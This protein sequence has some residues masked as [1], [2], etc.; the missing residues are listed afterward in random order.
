MT[1]FVLFWFKGLFHIISMRFLTSSW[2]HKYKRRPCRSWATTIT[3]I[4]LYYFEFDGKNCIDYTRNWGAA[5]F[6]SIISS[7]IYLHFN[8][9]AA[10]RYIL[11]NQ[12]VVLFVRY[13]NLSDLHTHFHVYCF[14]SVVFYPEA[15]S[16]RWTW[17]KFVLLH[18]WCHA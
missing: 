11:F 6:F 1:I 7:N 15:T 10:N 17:T 2:L 4:M 9:I 12:Y 5:S 13:V 8:G 3:F 14:E 16:T 18:N